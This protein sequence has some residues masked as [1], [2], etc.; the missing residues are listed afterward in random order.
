V[1]GASNPNTVSVRHGVCL[2]YLKWDVKVVNE[3]KALM[4]SNTRTYVDC[5]SRRA[6][7]YVMSF[8]VTLAKVKL[9]IR[10]IKYRSV[11][12]LR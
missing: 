11:G 8:S 2:V 7:A 12:Q 3:E 1:T 6:A 5:T 9:L 4:G 10:A